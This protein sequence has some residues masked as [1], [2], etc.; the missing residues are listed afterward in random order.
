MLIRNRVKELRQVRAGELLPHP[1]SWRV[2]G[3]AQQAVLSALLGE[4]GIAGVLLG[5]PADGKGP[6]GDFSKL[7]IFDG[8]GR[9][10]RDPKQIW[11]IAVTDLTRPEADKMLAALHPV[12]EMAKTDPAKIDELIRKVQ[13]GSDELAKMLADLHQ[14]AID[15]QLA[16]IESGG[17]SDSDEEPDDGTPPEFVPFRCPVTVAQEQV[18]RKAIRA[19]KAKFGVDATGEAMTEALKEWLDGQD[20]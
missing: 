8:H 1:D 16:D 17:N 4:V 18:I 15:Q 6:D 20:A 5:F 3:E 9:R 10:E 19:A 2:H 7:M 13:T 14:E 12:A 11:P